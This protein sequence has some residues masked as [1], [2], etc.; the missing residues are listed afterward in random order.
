MCLEC[1][2][3]LLAPQTEI[4][5]RLITV[6]DVKDSFQNGGKDFQKLSIII[7]EEKFSLKTIS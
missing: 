4:K 2:E 6:K 5:V 7:V 1:L 3:V